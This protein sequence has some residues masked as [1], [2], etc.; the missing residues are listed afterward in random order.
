MTTTQRLVAGVMFQMKVQCQS[1]GIVEGSSKVRKFEKDSN[2]KE[3]ENNEGTSDNSTE[4]V[5][6][7]SRERAGGLTQ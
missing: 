4:L 7:M 6:L 5:N 1:I 2:T 3:N